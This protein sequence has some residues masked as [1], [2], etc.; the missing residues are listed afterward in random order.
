MG[1]GVPLMA[2]LPLFVAAVA[3]E[4]FIQQQQTNILC[5]SSGMELISSLHYVAYGVSPGRMY[6]KMYISGRVYFMSS[7]LIGGGWGEFFW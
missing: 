4:Y 2:I 5:G 6:G 1:D 7:F 3:S